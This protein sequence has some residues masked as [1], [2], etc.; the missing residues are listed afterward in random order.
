VSREVKFK[1][2]LWPLREKI[3]LYKLKGI[4]VEDELEIRDFNLSST[5]M[6]LQLNHFHV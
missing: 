5:S 1:T 2:K 6:P 3:E 4:E